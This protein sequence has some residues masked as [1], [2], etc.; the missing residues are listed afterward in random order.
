MNNQYSYTK[1]INLPDTMVGMER[2]LC[3]YDILDPDKD[4]ICCVVTESEANFLI[5]HL[6]RWI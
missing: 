3:W 5:S 2:M 1:R 4:I 6:N